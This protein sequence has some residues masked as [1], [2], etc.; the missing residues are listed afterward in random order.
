MWIA[1]PRKAKQFWSGKYEDVR[2]LKLKDLNPY[3]I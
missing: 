3:I 1:L 2:R